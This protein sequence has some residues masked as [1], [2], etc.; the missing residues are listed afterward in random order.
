MKTIQVTMD[1]KLLEKLDADAETKR[2]GR[3]AV[4][5]RAVTEYLRRRRRSAITNSYRRA[6]GKTA[7]LGTEFENWEDEGVWPTD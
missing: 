7:G 5:R 1:E 4:L 6:Y 2:D 3:S